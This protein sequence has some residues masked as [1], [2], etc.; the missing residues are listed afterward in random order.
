MSVIAHKNG[1]LEKAVE[2]INTA[3]KADNKNGEIQA[4]RAELL[5]LA[6]DLDGAL[7][8]ARRGV[9]FAPQNP[10]AYNNLGLVWQDLEEPEKAKKAFQQAI[11][12][13][14][15]TPAPITTWPPSCMKKRKK[16]RIM[17]KR[18]RSSKKRSP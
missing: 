5:R 1:H 2:F 18:P 8:A 15:T 3:A 12:L 17:K 13:I 9:K 4:H 6:E 14:K 11:D 10:T 7:K 16:K